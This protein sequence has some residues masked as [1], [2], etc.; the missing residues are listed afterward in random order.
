MLNSQQLHQRSHAYHNRT[1]EETQKFKRAV[2]APW[3]VNNWIRLMMHATN[4]EKVPEHSL[5]AHLGS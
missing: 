2:P 3:H 5:P 1:V 4:G